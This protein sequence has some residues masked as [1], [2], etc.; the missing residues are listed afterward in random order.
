MQTYSCFCLHSTWLKIQS[1]FLLIDLLGFIGG[2]T[3]NRLTESMILSK[4]TTDIQTDKQT[5]S[6]KTH[7]VDGKSLNAIR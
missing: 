4:Q 7:Y 6:P 1:L 2:K 5:D 3:N